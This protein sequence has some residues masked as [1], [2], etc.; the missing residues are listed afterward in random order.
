[1]SWF[2]RK[3]CEEENIKEVFDLLPCMKRK[4][5]CKNQKNNIIGGERNWSTSTLSYV[6]QF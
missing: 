1:M 2:M 3:S 4:D 6:R 5:V